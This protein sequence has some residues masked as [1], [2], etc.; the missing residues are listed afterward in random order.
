MEFR[1]RAGELCVFLMVGILALVGS[2][3]ADT[4]EVI[5]GFDIDQGTLES[6]QTAFGIPIKGSWGSRTVTVGEGPHTQDYCLHYANNFMVRMNYSW[7]MELR[8]QSPNLG[9]TWCDSPDSQQL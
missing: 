2:V 9:Y 3:S 7:V 8:I 1:H 4:V 5:R 6:V